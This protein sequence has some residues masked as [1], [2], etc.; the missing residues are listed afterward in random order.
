MAHLTQFRQ[1]LWWPFSLR[2]GGRHGFAYCKLPFGR[3]VS[4]NLDPDY[5]E[6]VE[7][8]RGPLT[9]TRLE[10]EE[11]AAERRYSEEEAAYD[12]YCADFHS[13]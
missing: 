2:L 4:W 10:N 6:V 7:L 13:Y 9:I 1:P 11:E 5:D 12:E 8:Q 3:Y